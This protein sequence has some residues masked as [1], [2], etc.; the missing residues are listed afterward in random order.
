MSP[1]L[2]QYSPPHAQRASLAVGASPLLVL[3]TFTLLMV[4]WLPMDLGFAVFAAC[5]AWVVY[6]MHVYQAAI[7]RYNETYVEGHLAWRSDE[8]LHAL[9]ELPGTPE[10]TRVFVARFLAAQRVLL[11]DGQLP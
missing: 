8:D 6:E 11:R 4:K 2:P 5:T 9:V 10:A 1:S 3:L 7:D